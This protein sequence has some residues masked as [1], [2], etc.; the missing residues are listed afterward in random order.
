MNIYGGAS[1][2]GPWALVW[3]PFTLADCA[4]D[5]WGTTIGHAE[6]RLAQGYAYYKVEF[7]A[8]YAPS[9]QDGGGVKFTNAYFESSE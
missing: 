5:R 9:G 2:N 8:M 3:T 1:P 4:Q 6:A 7:A